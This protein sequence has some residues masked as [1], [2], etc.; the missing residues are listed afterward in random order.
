M[1]FIKNENEQLTLI[2]ASNFIHNTNRNDIRSLGIYST[3]FTGGA[4]LKMQNYFKV[5]LNFFEISRV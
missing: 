5:G 1:T 4:L 3:Q 2:N